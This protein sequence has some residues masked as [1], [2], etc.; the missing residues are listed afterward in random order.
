[1]PSIAPAPLPK[2][3]RPSKT[4]EALDWAEIKVIDLSRFDEPVEKQRLAEELR[5]AVCDEHNWQNFTLTP[6]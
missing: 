1:M 3:E 6:Y 2:W 4:K 5:D